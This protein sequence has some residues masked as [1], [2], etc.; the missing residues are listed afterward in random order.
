MG[1]YENKLRQAKKIREI[2]DVLTAAGYVTLDEQAKALGICRS[3]TWTLIKATHKTSGLSAHL[4]KRM[5]AAPQLPPPVREK[6]T[7][8]VRERLAGAYGH[9]PM[10]L[11]RFASQLPSAA[12]PAV[13]EVLEKLQH[14]PS[15][16]R[17][18]AVASRTVAAVLTGGDAAEA[19]QGDYSRERQ[20]RRQ[21]TS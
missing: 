21:C 19:S 1:T 5:L 2:S 15:P 3:T 7:E 12:I 9:S 4:I 10:Q 6:I 8:Y 13:A 17:P 20:R 18:I 11:H 14:R 16:R